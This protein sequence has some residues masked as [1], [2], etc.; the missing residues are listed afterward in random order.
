[1]LLREG[2]D[3]EDR[4]DAVLAVVR[5]DVPADGA[6]VRPGAAARAAA[7]ASTA[8][9]A[10]AGRRRGCGDARARCA[11]ARAAAAGLRIEQADVELVPLHRHAR[12]IQP[13]GAP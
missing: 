6:D 9:C 1:M 10:R 5:M 2:E 8:A 3:A 4:A 7:P 12:P 13:G 11:G